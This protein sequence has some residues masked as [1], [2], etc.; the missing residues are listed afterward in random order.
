MPTMRSFKT[1]R[2]N[3]KEA[4]RLYRKALKVGPIT[5]TTLG[6][7]A[8][9]HSEV[10]SQEDEAERLY[11]K[12]LELDPDDVIIGNF[13]QFLAT[14]DQH[15]EARTLACRAWSIFGS[16][17]SRHSGRLAFNRWLLDRAAGRQGSAGLGR[18][19]TI[20]ETGFTRTLWSFERVLAA[21]LP[22]LPDD[23]HALARKIADAILDESKVGALKTEPLWKAVKPIPLEVPWPD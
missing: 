13:V 23:E 12:A 15:E 6:N 4:E 2:G 5:A 9:F 21:L 1:D 3:N 17:P 11:R 8:R 20:L 10:L 22:R 16:S 7:F 14:I 19:K 18:L